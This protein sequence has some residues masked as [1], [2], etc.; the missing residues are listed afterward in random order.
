MLEVLKISSNELDAVIFNIT[1]KI[2]GVDY[3]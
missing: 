1:Q 3:N 2:A